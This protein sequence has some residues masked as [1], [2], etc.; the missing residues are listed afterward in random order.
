VDRL[1]DRSLAF[2]SEY[3]ALALPAAMLEVALA[4]P[5]TVSIAV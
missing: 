3:R 5:A 2:V 4:M 1:L